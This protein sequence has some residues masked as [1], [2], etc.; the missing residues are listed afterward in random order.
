MFTSVILDRAFALPGPIQG[1]SA[2]RVSAAA[3][4]VQTIRSNA[5]FTVNSPREKR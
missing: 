1:L 3:M 4:T 5:F 2:M